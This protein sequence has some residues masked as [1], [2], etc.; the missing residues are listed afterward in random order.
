MDGGRILL[1]SDCMPHLDTEAPGEKETRTGQSS[2][3]A[4][5]SALIGGRLSRCF[6]LCEDQI[7]QLQGWYKF[8]TGKNALLSIAQLGT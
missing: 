7:S 4:L 8:K 6:N 1:D 5:F 3:T 2:A